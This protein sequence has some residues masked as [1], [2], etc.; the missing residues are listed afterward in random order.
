[1]TMMQTE[2]EAREKWCP[3][4]RISAPADAEGRHA[5]NRGVLLY[6]GDVICCIAAKCALWVRGGIRLPDETGIGYCGLASGRPE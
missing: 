1:M 2:K 6:D 5:T 3:M 4:V